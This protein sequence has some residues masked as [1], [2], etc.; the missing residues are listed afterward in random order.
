MIGTR[1]EIMRNEKELEWIERDLA[2]YLKVP[3]VRCSYD[4]INSH[5]YKDKE[6][7][8]YRKQ[9]VKNE[10]ADD[11]I[12]DYVINYELYETKEDYDEHSGGYDGEVYELHYLKTNGNSIY[13]TWIQ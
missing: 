12:L 9:C 5:K 6:E 1:Y 4:D 11:D 13:I 10:E 8:K 7:I 3:Y 2:L